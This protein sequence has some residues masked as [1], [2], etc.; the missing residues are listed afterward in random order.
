MSEAVP[1]IYESEKGLRQLANYLRSPFGVRVR[2]AIEHEKRV[3][4]FKGKRLV[5]CILEAKKWPKALPKITDKGQAISVIQLL[6]KAQYFHRSEKVEG[7]KGVL[8]YSQKNFFEETG[9]YTWMYAGNMV[10]SN[11]A[12]G[13]VI[14]VVIGFTLLP[15]WPVIAKTILWYCSI[16]FLLVTLVFLSIR[17]LMFLVMWI[18]GYDFWVFPRLFDE[19]LTVQ[20]SF[21][22]VY[23]LEKGAS[24][25]G[26]Y[27]IALVIAVIA[28]IAW[29]AHQPTEFD[30][31]LKAQKEFIDDLYSGNL[32]A[33]VAH[34][35]KLNID[36][37]RKVPNLED[38]LRQVE[39]DEKI[40]AT[41]AS[42]TE[43]MGDEGP[44]DEKRDDGTGEGREG[45]NGAISEEKSDEDV[46]DKMFQDDEE[47]DRKTSEENDGMNEK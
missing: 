3:D 4:Y 27:R 41:A 45:M 18:L 40:A 38:L 25:Q 1:Q 24:G 22:P 10:W 5:E 26:Y 12:T 16:T 11:V 28:F 33:D 19:T 15:V 14:A 29:A 2:S 42:D 44:S 21:K 17:F 32:L 7:K 36:R 20:E 9:Y 37:S 46:I 23:Q 34:D 13:G 6:I 8:V 31:I 30:E 43:G 35:P 39:E 47:L